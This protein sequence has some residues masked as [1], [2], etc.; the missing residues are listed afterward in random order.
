MDTSGK[1][2]Y[3]EG[4]LD[5]ILVPGLNDGPLEGTSDGFI[6]G[7]VDGDVEGLIDGF[8]VGASDG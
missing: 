8:L 3:P 2:I 1:P 4:L 5:G 7:F 6:V